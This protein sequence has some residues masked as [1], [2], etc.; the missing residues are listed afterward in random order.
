M[1]KGPPP[2]DFLKACRKPASITVSG[3]ISSKDPATLSFIIKNT[4]FIPDA[5]DNE[6]I[7]IQGLLDRSA[8]WGKNPEDRL[9]YVGSNT[10]FCAYLE[11]IKKEGNNILAVLTLKYIIYMRRFKAEDTAEPLSQEEKN[12]LQ[13][14]QHFSEAH[15]PEASTSPKK[16]GKRKAS[17][18][19]EEV[20]D[21][22]KT[23]SID[24][25]N[26]LSD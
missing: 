5:S 22:I 10:A 6:S 14:T 15:K 12:I 13:C 18:S 25:D 23:E 1:P 21:N 26:K 20:S 11:D 7:H 16:L 19:D 4:Q 8:R 3:T 17:Y 9:P 24:E 2:R